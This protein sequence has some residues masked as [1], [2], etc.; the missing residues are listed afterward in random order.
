VQWE[1]VGRNLTYVVR[2]K[3]AAN[4][5]ST[6]LDRGQPE[7]VTDLKVGIFFFAW[8]RDGKQLAISGAKGSSD[9]VL[10]SDVR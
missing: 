1:P 3:G 7:R 5:W 10:I 4:I 6:S 9:V 2:E 8:S